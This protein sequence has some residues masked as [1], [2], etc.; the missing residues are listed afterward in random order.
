MREIHF[1]RGDP[2]GFFREARSGVGLSL[3]DRRGIARRIA[4]FPVRYAMRVHRDALDR[5]CVVA[6]PVER[7]VWRAT[8]FL[9]RT[10]GGI[11]IVT[12]MPDGWTLGGTVPKLEDA[13][14]LMTLAVH[15]PHRLQ[16]ASQA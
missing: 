10:D 13:L 14:D 8:F 4:S 2:D 9:L 16:R 6:S 1:I 5:A 15:R 12:R 7:S 11:T 3:K